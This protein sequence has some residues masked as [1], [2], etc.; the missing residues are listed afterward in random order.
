MTSRHEARIE[1]RNELLAMETAQEEEVAELYAEQVRWERESFL[2]GLDEEVDS[3]FLLSAEDDD[4]DYTWGN[5]PDDYGHDP[6][7]EPD[8]FDMDYWVINSDC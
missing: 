5:E 2:L 1:I 7:P 6:E 8:N 3:S 4:D